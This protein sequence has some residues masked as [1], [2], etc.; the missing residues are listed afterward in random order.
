MELWI[1]SQNRLQLVKVNYCYI[2][3][4]TDYC[5]IVG[6]TIDSGPLIGRY[7]TKERALEVLDEIEEHI[8]K[9]GQ[10]YIL[11]DEKGLPAGL[12]NYGNIYEMPKE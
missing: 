6:E 4:Q 10:S 8:Q 3:E 7:K 2:M 12:R 1:R 5:C 11:T 9:Q